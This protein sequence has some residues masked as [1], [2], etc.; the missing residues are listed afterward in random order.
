[1][2]IRFKNDLHGPGNTTL[3]IDLS[4][5]EYSGPR[6]SQ[7]TQFQVKRARD[8]LCPQWGCVECG[9]LGEHGPQE[10]EVTVQGVAFR[11]VPTLTQVGNDVRVDWTADPLPDH[12]TQD[13]FDAA[14]EKVDKQ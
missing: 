2:L 12:L 10:Q 5:Y 14:A 7:L 9:L 11:V 6:S 3:A 13:M 8:T 4:M 1:M